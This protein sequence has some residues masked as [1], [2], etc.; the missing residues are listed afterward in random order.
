MIERKTYQCSFCPIVFARK[1]FLNMHIRSHKEENGS[2]LI[3]DKMKKPYTSDTCKKDFTERSDYVDHLI[4]H[5]EE[6]FNV[7]RGNL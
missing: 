5:S 6:E 4:N 7:F 3:N 2:L 1:D